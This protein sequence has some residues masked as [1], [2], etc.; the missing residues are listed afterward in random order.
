ML[1]GETL[2]NAIVTLTCSC[3]SLTGSILIILSYLVTR[4]R[5]TPKA[6]YLILH[7]AFSDFFW[8]LSS[9]I[10]GLLWILNNG[11]VPDELCYLASPTISFTRMASLIWTVCISF[12]VLMSVQKRKWYWKTQEQ[13]WEAY[14][15]INFGIIF[16]LAFPGTLLSIIK[17]H[18]TSS[19]LGCSPGYE[20]IGLW[21]EIFFTELLPITIGF[22]C[23]MYVFLTVRNKMSRSAFPQSVRKRRK[24]V[25]YHYI[26][27]CILCWIPTVTQYII[28]I[29]GYHSVELEI[30]A[31]TS[32]YASG[33]FNFL[34]FGMQDPHLKRSFDVILQ[35]MGCAACMEAFGLLT[36]NNL[37][38]SDVEK[39][40]MFEEKTIVRNADIAKDKKSIYRN[41]KLSRD[42]KIALYRERPDLN[43]KFRIAP[44]P[45]KEFRT[46]SNSTSDD[47]QMEEPLLE[48][49]HT[50]VT[51]L[52]DTPD[53]EAAEPELSDS[54]SMTHDLETLSSISGNEVMNALLEASNQD[55]SQLEQTRDS[56]H[57]P[58]PTTPPRKR[59]DSKHVANSYNPDDD[60]DES[61]EDEE[62]EEDEDLNA[63]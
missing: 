35:K 42:D 4:A 57:A 50:L 19:G 60:D 7:L 30:V 34:V 40:V 22:A 41:R 45:K 59:Q 11:H 46:R 17:Q 55:P 13:A 47:I 49:Q 27:V 23:N 44:A 21:Y 54:D 63:L 32:L 2:V 26:I 36:A 6:A 25:M 37:K 3:L 56:L 31:R 1:H 10:L 15:K 18:T 9:S 52:D 48:N 12:N 29:S 38:Q 14:R 24:R 33:F 28:E 8:F 53:V 43:P 61:S 20:P 16:I 5:S 39:I 51:E 58:P 62:D